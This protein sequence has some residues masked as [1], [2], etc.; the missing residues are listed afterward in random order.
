MNKILL[1]QLL[2]FFIT[3]FSIYANP[4][5]NFWNKTQK[6]TSSAA[7]GVY[8][9]VTNGNFWKSAFTTT[10]AFNTRFFFP[11]GDG[12]FSLSSVFRN[13]TLRSSLC[14]GFVGSVLSR[15]LPERHKGNSFLQV[16]LEN[17]FLVG[18]F[19]HT[20]AITTKTYWNCWN[21]SIR[22]NPAVWILGA[23]GAFLSCSW[24]YKKMNQVPRKTEEDDILTRR[25]S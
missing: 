19:A 22:D 6:I 23:T 16:A 11:S 10:S 5:D 14:C 4:D 7:E 1:A 13:N 2:S 15:S 25:T 9:T 21:S 3:S 17:P 8:K 18:I 12:G 24:V 20:A